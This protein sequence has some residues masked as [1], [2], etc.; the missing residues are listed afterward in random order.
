[1]KKEPN[2]NAYFLAH[3]TSPFVKTTS[4][5]QCVKKFLN[6]SRYNS[7]FTATKEYS[8]YW[9]KNKPINFKKYKLCR[10]QDLTPNCKRYYF[11]V[12]NFETRIYEKKISYWI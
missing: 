12:W 9:F 4:I 10:S 1:M 3:V 11:F 7:V 2:Y 5:K 8:W 6:N